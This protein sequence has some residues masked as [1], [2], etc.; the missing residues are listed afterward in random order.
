MDPLVKCK[1]SLALGALSRCIS[2]ATGRGSRGSGCCCCCSHVECEIRSTFF[3]FL[4]FRS[5]PPF[6][7]SF[8]WFSWLEVIRFVTQSAFFICDAMEQMVDETAV[9]DKGR[10]H[11]AVAEEEGSAWV[12][13]GEFMWL[14]RRKQNTADPLALPSKLCVIFPVFGFCS[15]SAAPRPE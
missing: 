10:K 11:S 8:F 4:P 1:G 2:A 12:R 7:F 14:R 5:P 15:S 3:F 6:F 13:G 9:R